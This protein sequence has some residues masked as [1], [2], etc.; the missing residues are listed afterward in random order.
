MT[1]LQIVSGGDSKYFE[2]LDELACSIKALSLDTEV[3]LAFLD[4]GLKEEQKKYFEKN[5]VQVL[6]PGWCSEVAEKR[7]RGRN[8]LKINVAKLHLDKIF[9][10][11]DTILWVDG[12]TWFQTSKAIDYFVSVAAKNKL[13]IVSQSSRNNIDTIIYKN[14]FGRLV[15]LR[16]ILYKNAIRSN[17]PK[18]LINIL[19]AKSTLNAGAYALKKDAPHWER[20]RYWQQRILK[21]GR[22]FTSDQLSMGLTIYH[23]LLPFEPLP[24]ICNYFGKLRWNASINKFVDFYVPNDPIS[25]IHLAAQDKIRENKNLEHKLLDMNDTTVSK[26]IRFQK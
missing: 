24:D 20:F 23:D 15:E 14:W 7:S 18:N 19:K 17:L 1:R 12:D 21:K 10:K 26:K 2:L 5:S 4:G 11:A 3:N 9:P 8:F 22:V 6:D 13:G 25:I 16:N